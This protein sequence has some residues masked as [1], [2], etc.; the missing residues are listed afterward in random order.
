MIALQRQQGTGIAKDSVVYAGNID[1]AN[2]ITVWHYISKSHYRYRQV[3]VR[4]DIDLVSHAD[5]GRN[6]GW[7]MNKIPSTSA[8]TRLGKGVF[9]REI[10]E[11]VVRGRYVRRP[12]V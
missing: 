8:T 12:E 4:C 9:V 1:A 6:A 11:K 10:I 5:T 7:S 3:R 2:P